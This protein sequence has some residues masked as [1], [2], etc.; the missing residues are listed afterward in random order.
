MGL[1]FSRGPVEI[2]LPLVGDLSLPVAVTN[3]DGGWRA[4]P[5]Q[6]QHH[7]QPLGLD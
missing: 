4:W 5:Y 2:Y 1:K 3:K 7:G 6:V